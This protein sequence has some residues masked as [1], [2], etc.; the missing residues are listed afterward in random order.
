VNVAVFSAHAT[1]IELCLFDSAGHRELDRVALPERTG[2]VFHG[3]V[4]GVATSDRYGLRAHG[5]YDPRE[6][7]RFNAAKLLVD[8]YVRALDRGFVFDPALVGGGDERTTR[9]DTDSAP[10]VPKGIVG[11]LPMAV[12]AQHPRVPWG[13][14]V[15]YELHVR[16]F[17]EAHPGVPEALRGTCAGLAHPSALQHLTR[18]GVTTVELMPIVAAVDERHLA[19]LGLTNYWGYNPGALFVPSPRLAPGGIDELRTCVA[20]LQAAGIEVILDVVLNHTGE[21]DAFGPTLS[22]RGLD[23]ATYYRTVSDNRT[24]YVD[25]TGT[26][27]TLALDRA[28]VLRLALDVL[29]YYAEV[30]GV[31][32][33]RF[34]LAAILGRREDGFD[35]AAPLLQAIAQ[36]PVLRD[37]KLIAEPWD[38]GPA[39]YRLGAFPPGWGEWNDR[40]R[41]TVRRF[42]RGDPLLAGDFATRIAGSADLF[43]ARS[44]PPSRS[45]NFVT[46]HDGFTLADLVSYATKHN[47]ANGEDNRDG[48]DTNWSW[49]HGVEGPTPDP[50]IRATR[51]RDARNLLAT[52]LLSRGTPMLAMGDELGRTQRGNNNAYAQDSA[53]TWIDW[54]RADDALINFVAALIDLRKRSPALRDDR[55]L[56]GGPVDESGIPD[57]EWRHPDG[58]AMVGDDWTNP[59]GRVIVAILR[60]GGTDAQPADRVAVAFNAGNQP[61]S[62]LWPDARDGFSWRRRIN[63]AHQPGQRDPADHDTADA[64]YV[65]A[66]SVLVVAEGPDAAPRRRTSTVAPEILDRLAA[67]AGIACEWW[68]V[69]GER[70]VVGA[71]T[72][73]ALLAAMG[74]DV[75]STCEARGR[76][77][78]IAALREGRGLPHV[79]VAREGSNI[80]VALTPAN[81]KLRHRLR[82]RMQLEDGTE[83]ALP[84]I[85]DD[86]PA[87]GTTTAD[88]R[89]VVQH[90]LTLPT[91]PVGYHTLHCDGDSEHRCRI[92]VAPGRCFLPSEIRDGARR[93][94]LAA[95]LYAIRRR[96]DLGIGD[97]ATLAAIGEA[98]GRAGG[99]MVGIN[100]LHALFAED[101]ERASPYHPSDRR[102]V[103]P[104]Y[105]DVDHVP[106]LAASYDA[107]ALMAR[108]DLRV[109]ALRT[110]ADVDYTGVWQF[111]RA[112]LEACFERF[113]QRGDGDPLIAEFDRF[114]VAGGSTLRQFALFEAIAAAHPR[115]PWYDW[116]QELRQPDAPG[117]GEFAGRHS[118][119][120][121]FALYLQWLADRQF[122]AAARD[123]RA[124][125]LGLGFF[126]D[127]AVGAAPDGAEVWANQYAFARG[128]AI[129]AP[130]DPF[131]A[132]G[133]NWN[134]PPQN[135]LTLMSS[136]LAKFGDLL[137]ANMRYA[138]A[139]RI[140]HVMGLSRLYWIPDGATAA[141]G[142]YVRYPLDTLLAVLAIES[143]RARCF[144]VGEDLG[145]VPEGLRERLAAVDVL[146][147]RVLWFERD[148]SGFTAPSRYPAKAVACVSTH[149]L[150]TIAGWWSGADIAEKQSLG[151]LDADGAAAADVERMDAKR[152]LAVAIDAAG[153][154]EGVSIDAG[155]PHDAAITSAIH[156][157]L[158][159]APSAVVLIQADDL[160]DETVSLNL[161]GTDRSRPNW[162]R[163]LGVNA[164]ALWRT[165][166]GAQVLADFA[167]ARRRR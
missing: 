54:E 143:V 88:G 77:S 63:T 136:G 130:P 80:E 19:S 97:F 163:K 40:Y 2:D 32:G 33:F 70:H 158:C 119:P 74:L 150:P 99:S 22:L 151:M 5:P 3:F 139:L 137:V 25:D 75:H 112:V 147:Y 100:P 50:E 124:S 96:G 141:D 37:L 44:R 85:I 78:E 111:K 1:A 109:A 125:G 164:E 87:R 108:G 66:H 76:L 156:R 103:D 117:I 115:V 114:V 132:A 129:G 107:R 30:A 62:V 34:D 17:T 43:A 9:D 36:D 90:M 58:R 93:F 162:R 153:V 92:V 55:W 122:G 42:W 4:G 160:A 67:A 31:D 89:T 46:A 113:E 18:L 148:D 28:P 29:R 152:A 8:P 121:R 105:I 161:P 128:A 39:G 59:D 82:L 95:H 142:A 167:V 53:L 101:R 68:D 24:R 79:V 7:H 98:T 27:N 135:P 91:L 16:G 116:P 165:P 71:D 47:E 56:T 6:G 94:G 48:T 127:L 14:T 144:V 41:D 140:D 154:A 166:A 72:K 60:A 157:Y 45:V 65:A 146:S 138:G 11:P 145:T 84:F 52:L 69:T 21:G 15:I 155:A 120:V 159:A 102:F 61:V 73:R 26:G 118:R 12:N 104:I 51:S 149:D 81:A 64:A 83:R 133:Q 86:L 13:K 23:N 38:V 126:R 57:V 10:F 35:P 123:A 134:L 20:T 110:A 106:D 49:N 131:S